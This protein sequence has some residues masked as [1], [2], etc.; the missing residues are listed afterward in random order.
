MKL[1]KPNDITKEVLDKIYDFELTYWPE[2]TYGHLTKE[3]FLDVFETHPECIYCAMDDDGKIMGEFNILFPSKECI[4]RYFE[5]KEFMELDNCGIQKGKNILYLNTALID[6]KYR[7]SGLLK[8]LLKAMAEYL[9][10]KESEGCMIDVAYGEAVT[11]GGGRVAKHF[12]MEGMDIDEEGIGHYIAKDGLHQY[13]E[14]MKEEIH[15][16]KES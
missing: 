1:L 16:E 8:M 14:K 11:R 2:G 10:E 12:G 9:I 13:L 15:E 5:T 6:E 3:Y 4:D 7:G